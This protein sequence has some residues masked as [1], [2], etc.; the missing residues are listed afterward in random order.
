[1]KCDKHGIITPGPE[2]ECSECLKEK[3]A[4]ETADNPIEADAE[5]HAAEEEQKD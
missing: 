2:I 5:Q 1:M 4:A 3:A